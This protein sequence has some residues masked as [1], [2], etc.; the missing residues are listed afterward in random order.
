M[1]QRGLAATAAAATPIVGSWV[2]ERGIK[3]K[4]NQAFKFWFGK[5]PQHYE[6]PKWIFVMRPLLFCVGHCHMQ[7][8]SSRQSPI[9][10]F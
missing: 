1:L 4:Q 6:V 10:Q 5:T 8:T 7:N 9:I 3:G 2:M